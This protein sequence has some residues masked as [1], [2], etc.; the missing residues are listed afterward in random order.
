MA[1]ES[2]DFSPPPAVLNQA[3]VQV[4]IC[5]AVIISAVTFHLTG[6]NWEGRGCCRGHLRTRTENADARSTTNGARSPPALS[7][8][9]FSFFL[10]LTTRTLRVV[11]QSICTFPLDVVEIGGGKNNYAF[12]LLFFLLPSLCICAT[13]FFYF[14]YFYFTFWGEYCSIV[15]SFVFSLGGK[16]GR[17]EGSFFSLSVFLPFS[18]LFLFFFF[19]SFVF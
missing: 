4:F 5:R 6:K 16:E 7:Y 3:S 13:A 17:K 2:S 15:R 14:I 18:V 11:S 12:F 10:S 8:R 19:Y 9:F 1:S